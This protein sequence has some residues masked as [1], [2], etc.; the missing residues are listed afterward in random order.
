MARNYRG[1]KNREFAA[2]RF[3]SEAEADAYVRQ[4]L[5]AHP[6]EVAAVRSG[7]IREARL[8]LQF[9]QAIGEQAYLASRN[10]EMVMRLVSRV[11]VFII[12]QPL[13][14]R[15]YIVLTAYPVP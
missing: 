5:D 11:R 1:S 7:S 2:S 12:Y 14:P 3:F 15:G 9:S 13:S 8:E 10:A 6:A 4:V